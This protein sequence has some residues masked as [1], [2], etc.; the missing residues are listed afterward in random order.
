MADPHHAPPG[1]SKAPGYETR[2]ANPAVIVKWGIGLTLMVIVS[3]LL[4]R[5]LFLHDVKLINKSRPAVSPLADANPV[6]P[7]PV[8]QANPRLE[9]AQLRKVE[10]SLLTRYE[11]VQEDAKILRIPVERAMELVARQGLPA[12]PTTQP[13]APEAATGTVALVA[14]PVAPAVAIAPAAAPDAAVVPAAEAPGGA[15]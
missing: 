10:A 15:P 9:L 4:M 7:A 8:L 1:D 6:P 11:W 12:W 2:D 13:V 5:A 3:F 14:A